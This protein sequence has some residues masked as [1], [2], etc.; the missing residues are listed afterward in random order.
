MY[1]NTVCSA[2]DTVVSFK[3]SIFLGKRTKNLA[4]GVKNSSIPQG[5]G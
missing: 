1:E 3:E 4:G 5:F 2:L